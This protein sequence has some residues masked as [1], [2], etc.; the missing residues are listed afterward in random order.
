VSTEYDLHFY[1][2]P[3]CPF[4]WLTSKWVSF[5]VGDAGIEED[6][7]GGSRRLKK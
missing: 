7:H 5:G 4:A 3:V 1:F 2:D 6:W